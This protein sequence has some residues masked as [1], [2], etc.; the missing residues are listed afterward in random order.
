MA[1]EGLSE[2]LQAVFKKLRGKGRV[3]EKDIKEAMREVRVALLEAD[4]NFKVVKEFVARV[5]EK[6]VGSDVLE[7]LT[8]GQQI[9]KIVRDE[10]IELMGGTDS[11]IAVSPKP[12]TVI[13]LAGLNGAGKTTTAAKLAG[14]LKKQGK[15]PILAACDVYRPAAVTQL[16]V[17]GEKVGVP[18][19][20]IEGAKDPVKIAEKAVK[21]CDTSLYDTVIIDTAGRLQINAELMEELANI[22]KAA[23]PTEVLLVVDAMTGQ[24][25]VNIAKGFNDEVGIDGVI[26][27]KLDG[28][29]RGGAALSVKAVTGKPIKFACTGEKVGDIEVFYPD[30][31]ASRILGMGDILTLIDKAQESFDEKKALELEQKMRQQRFDLNDFLEQMEQMKNMGPISGILNMIPGINKKALSG[32]EIDDKQIDRIAAIIKSMTPAERENPSIINASRKQRIA[33][34]SGREVSDVNRLLKQFEDMRKMMKQFMKPGAKRKMRF[35]F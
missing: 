24:D 34:G 22:K 7:S 16:E 33:K 31:M 10:M 27:T 13:L 35:P 29:T 18:I 14:L 1:F 32:V 5:S 30:R 4:V 19:F 17:V 2:K 28:D 12:P 25:A 11:K 21:E 6:A 23:S 8:P 9:I 20:K 26:L 15:R 3:S